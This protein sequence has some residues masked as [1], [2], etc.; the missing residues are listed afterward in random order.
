M[1]IPNSVT[2]RAY[3]AAQQAQ[4][5]AYVR[6]FINPSGGRDEYVPGTCRMGTGREKTVKR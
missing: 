5:Q 1:T 3:Q 4:S 6:R 2:R